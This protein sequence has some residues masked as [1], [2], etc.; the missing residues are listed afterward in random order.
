MAK[1]PAKGKRIEKS[2][3]RQLALKGADV[4]H[5]RDLLSDYM[6]LWDTKNAL[7][8][9]IKTRGIGY[10]EFTSTGNQ[11]WKNNPSVKELVMVNRQ[12]LTI[13]KDLKLSTDDVG[14]GE[15]DDL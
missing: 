14:G 8:A 11:V 9:N 13:L 4:E 1:R 5:Y 15:D 7:I 6:D 2:L 10:L 3:Q 12:M